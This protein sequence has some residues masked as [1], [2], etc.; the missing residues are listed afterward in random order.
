MMA[1][2]LKETNWLLGFKSITFIPLHLGSARGLSSQDE[3]IFPRWICLSCPQSI[4][5]HDCLWITEYLIHRCAISHKI[6]FDQRT[7]IP[8]PEWQEWA[9]DRGIHCSYC[10]LHQTQTDS[11]TA[12]VPVSRQYSTGMECHLSF[13][14]DLRI[15]IIHSLLYINMTLVFHCLRQFN[16]KIL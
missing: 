5:Q 6:S 8:K 7:F 9:H 13:S 10:V 12:A 4:S 3:F 2:F 16:F 1:L 14:N 15:K 11:C